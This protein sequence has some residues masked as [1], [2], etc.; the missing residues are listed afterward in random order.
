M[1]LA[2]SGTTEGL[3]LYL[4]LF[5][6]ADEHSMYVTLGMSQMELGLIVALF[7]LGVWCSLSLESMRSL[8]YT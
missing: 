4:V 6:S 2:C 1:A 3:G 7:L 5:F 8:F